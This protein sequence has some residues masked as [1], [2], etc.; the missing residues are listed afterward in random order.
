MLY[1]R[2][3]I[4]QAVFRRGCIESDE[5]NTETNATVFDLLTVFQ[6]ILARHKEEVQMEIE[7]E[8]MSLAEMLKQIKARIIRA[9]EINLI[10][11][12]RAMQ[13]RQELVLAFIAILE[14][15]RTDDINLLQKKTF[16]DI[17]LKKV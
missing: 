8:E 13:T 17:I 14:L 5:N 12:F 11:I 4:E 6:K 9:G 15:V 3:T 10:E 7:R 16:G 1:E 2:G